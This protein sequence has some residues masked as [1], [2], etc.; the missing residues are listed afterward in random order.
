M[1]NKLT[2]YYFNTKSQLLHKIIYTCRTVIY[3]CSVSYLKQF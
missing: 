2:I 3:C 1:Y